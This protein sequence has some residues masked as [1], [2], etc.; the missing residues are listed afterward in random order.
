VSVG[1]WIDVGAR[2]EELRLGGAAH[3]LEHLLFK[4]TATRTARDIAEAFDAV[5][6]E[7]N[8]YSAREHTC[9]YARVLDV[10]LP[11]AVDVL[12]DMF[13]RGALREEDVELERR[14][15]LEEI[16]MAGDVPEDRVHDVFSEAAWGTHALGRQV[17]GTEESITGMQ[18]DDLV[19]YYRDSY[20]PDRLVVAAAGSA[21]H[22]QI[23]EL[24]RSGLTSGRR[25][26]H[27]GAEGDPVFGGPAA[28]YETRPSEQVHI[29]WGF[30]SLA[31]DDP[32]R[33]ALSILNALYGGGMSSRLFQEI[34]E[35]RGL[36][37][38]VYSG[39]SSYVETGLFSVYVGTQTDAA[40]T[41]LEI[42][43]AQAAEVAGGGASEAEVERAK[44]Q[45]R[46][47]LVLSMDDPGGRM[48]RLGRSELVHG[49]IVA[50]DELI[51]RIDGVSASDVQRVAKRIF[52]GSGSVLACVGPV[53]EGA[54]DFAVEPLG[55]QG[56]AGTLAH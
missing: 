20:V 4:G 55:Q 49:E 37:Y 31:R 16:H 2:D 38:S 21:S 25:P 45:V 48:T 34:R 22:E 8:A 5:G 46:G 24:V 50:M 41:V 52:A 27:R 7:L 35:E 51:A 42:A 44:G 47:G 18:R 13:L 19:A 43:R 56:H 28:V 23:A 9:F 6:G 33:Y 11:L 26:W 53:F 15:V 3:L 14:V 36:A 12:C 32:D 30:E 39:Y 40:P 54:L 17:L 29:V 10:D 1:F